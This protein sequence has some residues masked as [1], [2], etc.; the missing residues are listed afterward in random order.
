M[1]KS[2]IRCERETLHIVK[3]KKNDSAEVHLILSSLTRHYH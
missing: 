2:A 3:E 1:I